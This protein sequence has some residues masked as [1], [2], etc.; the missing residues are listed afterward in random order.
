MI[1]M[2]AMNPM[3]FA[4]LMNVNSV[5]GESPKG[6]SLKGGG[7]VNTFFYLRFCPYLGVLGLNGQEASMARSSSSW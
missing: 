7:F 5:L 4:G 2:A 3:R 6:L 1:V